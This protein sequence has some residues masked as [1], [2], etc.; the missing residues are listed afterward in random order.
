MRFIDEI[1]KCIPAL[2]AAGIYWDR[3]DQLLSVTCFSDM[4]TTQQN[5]AFHGEGDVY[6]H[7]Q[8]ACRELIRM[9]GFLQLVDRQKAELFLATL[10]HDVGKVKTTRLEDGK[11]VSPH[12]GKTG[13]QMVKEFLWNDCG[14]CGSA[15]TIRFRET[16]CALVRYHM[17]PV[18]LMD[19]EEPERK[20]REIAA[21]GELAADFSWRLLCLL[22]EADARGRIA[23]DIEKGLIRV[24]LARMFAEEAGCLDEPYPFADGYT[25][26]A[27]L[28][29]RNVQP[30]ETLYD[31]TW[32]EVIMLSGLPGTG[33][34]TWVSRYD[35][36]LPMVSL[37]EIRIEL[38]VEAT[39]NQGTV[40][41]TAKERARQLL[42]KKQP[43]IL[44]ATNLT[45]DIRRKWVK[46]FEDYGARVRI[47]Y[48]E[49]DEKTREV[50]NA[51]RNNVVPEEAVTKMRNK[52]E[53][54]TL[55][56]AQTVEWACT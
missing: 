17:T 1:A 22:A 11:W 10:L 2:P 56:E 52:T 15:E 32:G 24:E 6:T 47:V 46:L 30:D 5:P 14:L 7:T 48:L 28:S 18:H 8:M 37:D 45:K 21:T 23:N 4:K 26:Y 36:N 25:K 35:P 41:Q 27:Y 38:S 54:P 3:I 12:H 44:N 53:L 20:A 19:Y 49:T 55:D 51:D 50:R 39:D 9:P 34:D 40:V 29:G 33:K 13:S 31:D 42:R 16:V 43:F